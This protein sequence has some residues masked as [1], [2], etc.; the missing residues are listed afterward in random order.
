VEEWHYRTNGTTFESLHFT[1]AFDRAEH[2]DLIYCDPP[3]TDTQSIL[4]GA[5]QFSLYRLIEKIDEVKSRG[6]RVALSI[7]GSKKSGIH[8]VLHD[9]PSGLFENEASI[10]V[11]SSMLRRFQMGG[12][13]LEGEVVSDRLLL[14]Y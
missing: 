2:G 1:A 12:Q 14:T 7:D 10:T 6:V 9:F 4:Y 8:R 11:G 5:Q 3:Y 13:S